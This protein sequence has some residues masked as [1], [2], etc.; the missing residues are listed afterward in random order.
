VNTLPVIIGERAARTL[1]L[2]LFALQYLLVIYLVATGFFTP[3]MLSSCSP[4]TMRVW[5]YARGR[6]IPC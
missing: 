6:P 5:S 2:A 3:V 1:A 4:D